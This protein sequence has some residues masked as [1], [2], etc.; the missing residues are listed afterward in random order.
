[1]KHAFQKKEKVNINFKKYF[2]WGSIILIV[3]LIGLSVSAQIKKP[4]KYDE[5]AN[6]LTEKGAV[7]YGNDFCSYTMKQLGFFGKSQKLLN[8]V[9]CINNE[10]LCN[11]KGVDITP[12]WEINGETYSGVQTFEALAAY[13]GCE[14]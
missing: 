11:S 2:I 10:E 13:S 7:I 3:I 5:F 9:K 12:T 1:M 6:C 14:V 8:Y 4:G